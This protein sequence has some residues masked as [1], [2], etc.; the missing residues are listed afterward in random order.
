MS[1]LIGRG[2]EL[3]MEGFDSESEVRFSKACGVTAP[4]ILV[5]VAQNGDMKRKL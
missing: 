5:W 2:D 1:P 3:K 4:F